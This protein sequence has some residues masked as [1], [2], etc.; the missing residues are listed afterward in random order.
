MVGVGRWHGEAGW[1]VVKCGKVAGGELCCGVNAVL[2]WKSRL[3]RDELEQTSCLVNAV[4]D[5]V[6]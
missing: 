3:S 2:P 1:C 4:N 6:H 5:P